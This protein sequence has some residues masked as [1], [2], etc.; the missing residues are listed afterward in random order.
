[1]QICVIAVFYYITCINKVVCIV[2]PDVCIH[3]L[4]FSS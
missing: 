3:V 4:R 1:M 2:C